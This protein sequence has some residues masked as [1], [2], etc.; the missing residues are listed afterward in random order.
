MA[1]NTQAFCP[2]CE[3]NTLHMAYLEGWRCA[4]C[5]RINPDINANPYPENEY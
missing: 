4:E 1:N 3:E 2:N 5:D